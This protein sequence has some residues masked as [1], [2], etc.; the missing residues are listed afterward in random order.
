MPDMSR[1][2][3]DASSSPHGRLDD[4]DEPMFLRNKSTTPRGAAADA[5]DDTHE[6]VAAALA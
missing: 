6:V 1:N 3:E 4:N 2:N 5:E